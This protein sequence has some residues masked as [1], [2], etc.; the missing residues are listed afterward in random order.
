MHKLK[1]AIININTFVNLDS[2]L[3]E[4]IKSSQ[5]VRYELVRVQWRVMYL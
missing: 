1:I 5:P 2:K 3:F 4:K